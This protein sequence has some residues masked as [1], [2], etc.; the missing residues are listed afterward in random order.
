MIQR[1]QSIYLLM[2]TLLSFLFLNG[3]FL[4]FINKTGSLIKITFNGILKSTGAQ[5]FEMAGKVFP[6][7]ALIV[8]IPVFALITIFFFKNRGLQLW[9]AR[10][11]VGVISVF[12]L[13]SVYYSFTVVTK[14][15]T[16][17]IP[18]V[19]MVLPLLQLIFSF[20][21]FRGIRNDERLVKSYDRLR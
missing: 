13:A 4:S 7:T 10:I 18:G 21:A 6:L 16:Q 9:L 3:S 15:S 1:I 12:I 17:I 11:L 5:D 8:I 2:T 14:Y 19:K 20:L